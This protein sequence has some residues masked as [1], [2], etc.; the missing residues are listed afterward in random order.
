L[1]TILDIVKIFEQ[2]FKG[3]GKLDNM[4]DYL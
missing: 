4:N 1:K 3:T 2:A